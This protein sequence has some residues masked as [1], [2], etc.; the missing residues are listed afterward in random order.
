MGAG[1]ALWLGGHR[2]LAGLA[3][4]LCLAKPQLVLPLIGAL[5]LAR[6][7]PVIAGWTAAAAAA[8]AVASLRGPELLLQWLGFLALRAAHI[9]TE[10]GMVGLV[11]P[12]GLPRP[13]TVALLV[14]VVVGATIVVIGL[15]RTRRTAA[16]SAM[17]ILVSGGLLA[18]PHAL[19]Y[20]L[21][22]LS[23]AGAVWTGTR[24]FDWLILSVGGCAVA[25]L[26]QSSVASVLGVLLI[27]SALVRITTA[28]A[29]PWKADRDRRKD[30]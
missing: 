4:G 20:D 10:V 21:V 5:T 29:H 1:W 28:G 23:A 8:V 18:A 11:L 26:H 19:S 24:W 12:L 2:F 27:G 22:L 3:L 16:A 17:A 13:V 9:G 30:D 6:M 25:V 15:A 7:W 14:A